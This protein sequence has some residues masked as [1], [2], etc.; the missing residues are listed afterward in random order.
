MPALTRR[1]DPD[2]RHESWRVYY[3]DIHVGTIGLRAGV[4]A[5]V[6]QW[7]WSCPF[8]PMSHRGEGENG[9][10]P[11]F[12]KARTDFETAWARLL[13]KVTDAD[14]VAHRRERAWTRWK[15]AMQGSGC[16]MPTQVPELRSRCYCG[17]EIGLTCEQHVY[18]RH[19]EEA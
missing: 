5:S 1:C 19:M 15:Y 2:A 6:D 9:T 4:P 12:F 7:S 17:A 14:L 3:G 16:K 13:P 10:A 18:G 8:Y 11:N